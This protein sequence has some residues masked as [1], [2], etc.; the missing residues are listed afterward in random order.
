MPKKLTKLTMSTATFLVDK[1]KIPTIGPVFYTTFMNHN[2]LH[3][4]NHNALNTIY[5]TLVK[6]NLIGPNSIFNLSYQNLL[7]DYIL[8][9]HKFLK[10]EEKITRPT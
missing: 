3:T 1:T 7:W 4:M 8:N 9:L 5:L 6:S 2:P 10:H